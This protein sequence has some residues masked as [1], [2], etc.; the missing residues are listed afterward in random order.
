M[1]IKSLDKRIEQSRRKA[2]N[3]NKQ[4]YSALKRKD[5]ETVSQFRKRAK[6]YLYK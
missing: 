4:R 5:D 3:N 2:Y 6:K 1:T